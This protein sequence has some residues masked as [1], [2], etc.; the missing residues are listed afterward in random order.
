MVTTGSYSDYSVDSIWATEKLADAYA[1]HRSNGYGDKG[2]V[3]GPMTLRTEL[4][5]MHTHYKVQLRIMRHQSPPDAC[6]KE[7][8]TWADQSE[9]VTEACVHT[10]EPWHSPG[11]DSQSS[12]DI[13]VT[14]TDRERVGKVASEQRARC[15]AEFDVIIAGAQR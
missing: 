7:V 2:D 8:K 10:V 12:I 14:G 13:T 9:A 6:V 11:Y 15:I 1:E 3:E 5:E 4:P